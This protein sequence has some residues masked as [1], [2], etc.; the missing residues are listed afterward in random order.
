MEFGLSNDQSLL[1]N[2]V[3]RFLKEKVPLDLVR[4]VAEGRQTDQIIWSELTKLGLS[5]IM[6][7]ESLGGLGLGLLDASIIAE[8]LGY[9][10]TPSPYLTSAII[11]PTVL[12]LSK[13]RE[14]ILSKIVTGETR[15]GIAFN[16]A[17]RPA[18]E[19]G[20]EIK[21]G[22]L[23]GSL[24]FAI[25]SDADYYLVADSDKKI[26]LIDRNSRGFKSIPLSTVEKTRSSAELK[27]CQV[28]GDEISHDP[29]IFDKAW[30]AGLVGLAADNLGAAQCALDQAVEYANQRE[31]F[32]RVIASFQAVKHMCAE[33]AAQLEPCRAMVWYA[34]HAFNEIPEEST[35]MASHTK[36]HLS[37]VAQFVTRTATEVHGGMGFT[38]LVGLHYWFKRCGFNR[39]ALGSPELLR[40]RA[41]IAQDLAT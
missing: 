16:Q 33:M 26:Y 24:L 37:E 18:H 7:D 11:A 34:A 38:D 36:A 41:A 12:Q 21:N 40:D 15:V 32:N 29:D 9:A 27:F 19:S 3:A 14:D 10:V 13:K 22:K 20:F 4:A 25:D 31:Q 23:D 17:I 1:Q 30:N 5:G 2:Q 8:R 6:I 39:Q 35:M 28:E